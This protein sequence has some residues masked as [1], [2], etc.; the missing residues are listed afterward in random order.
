M[1]S[2]APG[3]R[4][5]PRALPSVTM[6]RPMTRRDR[7]L[8]F[9]LAGLTLALAS[10]TLVG[11][12]SD[13]LL[14]VP[15]LVFALPLLAGRYVGEQQLARLAAAFVA[16][17]PAPPRPR[18]CR[19]ARRA[20]HALPR[21]GRLIA[22]SLAV[23]PPP[24]APP[25]DRLGRFGPRA[26]RS[27][28]SIHREGGP[29][30]ARR[31]VRRRRALC[32]GGGTP[33]QRLRPPTRAT[34]TTS[35]SCARSRR[36]SPASPSRCSTATTASRS[37]TRAE[38]R[39]D[40]RLRRGAL[41]PH[42]PRRHGRGQ[43]ALAGVLPQPGPL[44]RREGARRRPMPKARAAVEGRRR[45][46]AATSFTTTACTG[47]PRACPQ[48][49]ND[50]AKRTKIFDWQRAAARAGR[51]AARSAA[52]C[53]GAAR[54]AG[55]PVGA[56]IALGAL[57]LLGGAAVVVV[58]RRRR[59]G[60]GAAGERRRGRRRARGGLVT[61][62]PRAGVAGR[63]ARGAAARARRPRSAHAM[64]VDTSPQRG[65]TLRSQP[66]AGRAALQRG[67][68]GQLRRRAR[69][70]RRGR[71]RRRRAH[72]ATPAAAARGSPSA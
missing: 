47:W 6:M 50:Q 62:A 51:D 25:P 22:S 13:V 65:A 66:R 17:A 1:S 33:R 37:R 72:R 11:V 40:R 24:A 46:P 71:A 58:R 69:L 28:A 42:A 4:R 55:A 27:R 5:L 54:T 60:G 34:R 8:L 44:L 12:H 23:R 32:A 48:Q 29:P 2:T 16:A 45:A 36:R 14:A 63:A 70:R 31:I 61:R 26:G 38:H 53:S 20:P 7:Q 3:R 59:A 39:H 15:A 68:R 19:R 35:R 52:S 49:V 43:P 41:R 64:L 67:R 21:G 57:V 18:S 9:A 10:L 30:M 56:F